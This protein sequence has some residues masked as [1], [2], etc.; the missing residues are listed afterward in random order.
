MLELLIC[1]EKNKPVMMVGPTGTG[2][3]KYI[4][5]VLEK[6]PADKWLTIDVG[7]SAQTGCNQV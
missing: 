7:F 1:Q 3:T 5:A 2:K 6:L 4:Q